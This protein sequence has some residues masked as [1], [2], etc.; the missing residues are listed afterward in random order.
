MLDTWL[1]RVLV[2]SL[3]FTLAA[4][5]ID[6][7]GLAPSDGGRP[8]GQFDGGFMC[9]PGTFDL[10]GDGRCECTFSS[11][12]ESCDGIDNDCDP[13]TPDGA[14]D[15]VAG[16]RCNGDDADFCEDGTY[17]CAEA[18]Y[19]CDE[20]TDNDAELCD[21][22]E[23]DDC[24]GVIDEGCTCTGD[25]TR[26]CGTDE[27]ECRRGLQ[28]CVDGVFSSCEGAQGPVDEICNDLDDD[29]D[30]R[31]DEGLRAGCWLDGDGDTYAAAGAV[32]TCA[33]ASGC[34]A[35]FT[36]RRP[37]S[38]AQDCQ[39]GMPSINPGAAEVCDSIDQDCDSNVNEGLA[40]GCW[41]DGDRDGYPANMA[42]GRC[43]PT[44]GCPSG[45][46]TR[47]PAVPANRDCN[48]MNINVN[49]SVREVCNGVDDDCV[50]GA[51]DGLTIACWTDVDGDG[52]AAM[53]AAGQCSPASG[54]PMG[55][56]GRNPTVGNRDCDDSRP[57]V[58]PMGT[59]TCNNRDD[60]CDTR[61][62]EGVTR[63]C[64]TDCGSGTETCSAGTFM[65]C[66]A[67]M[68]VAETC[69]NM[70]DDCDTR[71]DEGVT[72]MCSTVC[73][74]GTETCMAGTFV[75]CTAPMPSTETCNGMDDDCDGM[76]DE[77]LP[78]GC[79][80]D[81]DGDGFAAVDATGQCVPSGGCPMGTTDEDPS[82]SGN[83][84]CDPMNDAVY[85][86]A[87]EVCDGV[88]NNCDAGDDG[89]ECGTDCQGATNAGRLYVF[90]SRTGHDYAE[91]RMD[92]EDIGMMAGS[93]GMTLASITSSAEQTF[94]S[95]RAQ[96]IAAGDWWIGLHET[97]GG[98][99]TW[100]WEDGSPAPQ[101]TA[102]TSAAYNNWASGKP[103]GG[104]KCAHLKSSGEWDNR[105]C[106][107]ELHFI[108]EGPVP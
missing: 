69:N 52:Y 34:P 63:T 103:M 62:D 66:T 100:V 13:T 80:D 41:N 72:Q 9:A 5:A 67:R 16:T 95:S 107:N 61:T 1:S 49:P 4:C 87:V 106:D 21:G 75:G 93:A 14:N 85:P 55:T 24:D 90:C 59:E 19:R 83:A 46:T 31:T 88:D 43:L 33:P 56:T 79:W 18:G 76:D 60:D 27:G 36:N 48:D 23:D 17:V 51:D 10:D 70:D 40:F 78:L 73:G 6:R 39:D 102:D 101:N 65:G 84:D 30:G 26:S 54:C 74:N 57:S 35:G 28:R 96:G 68:P 91:G 104:G 58:S 8:D 50:G 81:P 44:G 7:S 3:A 12:I 2:T 97:S 92:C 82:V 89:D 20:P 77:G 25:D 94:V 98:D 53:S 71:T 86:G 32:S 22:V 99:A 105:N 42:P 37:A 45:T 11:D 64:T 47:D 38:G 15:P 29:C 108:C